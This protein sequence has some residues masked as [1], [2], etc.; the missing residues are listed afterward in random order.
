MDVRLWMWDSELTYK[1]HLGKE[2]R[3][4]CILGFNSNITLFI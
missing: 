4:I 3:R 1:D 2:E